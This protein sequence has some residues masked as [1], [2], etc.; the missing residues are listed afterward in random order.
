MKRWSIRTK[1]M[2]GVAAI[3]LAA[4]VICVWSAIQMYRATVTISAIAEDQLPELALATAFEREILNARIYFIYHVTIQKPGALDSG[5]KRFRNAQALIPKLRDQA[6]SSA[7]LEPLRAP[8]ETLAADLDQYNEVLQ[9]IL[10][11]VANH[12]NSG[13]S[14]TALVAEWANS[15]GR[16]VTMAGDLQHQCS[17]RA[18]QSSLERVRALNAALH[19]MTAACLFIAITGVFFGWRLSASIGKVLRTSVGELN[20]SVSQLK[21]VSNQV[22]ASSQS[23]AQGASEQAAALEESSASAEQIHAMAQR[24]SD[25]SNSAVQLVTKSEKEFSEAN[26]ALDQVVSAM[27]ELSVQSSSISKIIRV[28]DEIAFQTNIL[29]LNA[30]VEAARAG[31]AGLGFAVVADEV[32]NLA[33]RS[34]QAARD[35]ASLIEGS[36]SKS[37]DGKSR[38]DQMARIMRSITTESTQVRTL[39]D[40]VN[41]GSR[42]Q[43]RGISEIAKAI[44]QM[45]HVMHSGAASAEQGAAAAQELNTHSES[46][47]GIVDR[48]NILVHGA[49]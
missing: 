4:D 44:Q 16:L 45:E 7:A 34:A 24:N 31:E 47:A 5:W 32:R 49:R 15:G 30:S 20:E 18:T 36:I 21:A 3:L 1:L 29:A 22:A 6:A 2:A 42:E 43:S 38:V 17:E 12:Q 28:I 25:H 19:W 37:Q 9:R 39:V 35:T 40:E 11:V 26:H 14:F 33:Q 23:L 27:D 46:L 41:S 48:L 10:A 13:P 8:T